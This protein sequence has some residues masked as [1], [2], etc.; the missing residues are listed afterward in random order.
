MSLIGLVLALL[1]ILGGNMIEGGHPSALLDLPAFLIVIG[2][3]IGAALTQFPFSVVKRSVGRFKWLIAP[4][5]LDILAQID[6]LESLA[7]NARRSGMLALE[8][9]FDQINDPFLKKGVQMM[10]DGYDKE[11][12]HEVL[13]NE[14]EFE[15]EDIEQ[16][17]K[18]YEAMGGYCPTM[19]IVG[20][21]FGLI[22]AMGLLSAPDK[23]GGAIAV[24]FIATI[25]GVSAANLIFLPFGNRYKAFA[26]QIRHYK[27]MTLTGIMVILDGESQQRMRMSLSPYL[28]ERS[29]ESE[30]G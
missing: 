20:A 12:I 30:K 10:V 14:I 3:T 13:E 5:H 1:A 9:M 18:F 6:I 26:H 11:K 16:T 21:V 29:G 27:E 25:Y 28:G 23:L 4:L 19:G 15:Q 7:S 2:G 8:S 24:A 22:H 17:V